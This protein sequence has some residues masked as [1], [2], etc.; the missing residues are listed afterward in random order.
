MNAVSIALWGDDPMYVRGAERAARMWREALGAGWEVHLVTNKPNFNP[1]YAA[2]TWYIKFTDW[3][4]A[5]ARYA[6]GTLKKQGVSGN[7]ENYFDRV[8]F[9]DA[10]S[11]PV[12]RDVWAVQDWCK[13]E[14]PFMVIRDHPGHAMVPGGLWGLRPNDDFT[15]A[16]HGW[17][18]E[19][20]HPK[21]WDDQRWLRAR[22]WPLMERKGV[23]IYDSARLDAA[24]PRLT[25]W[26]FCG[27][28]FD[29]Y[30]KAVYHD[31]R[32]PQSRAR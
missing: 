3:G 9:R 5:F 8:I 11:V 22:V 19:Y 25:D 16:Y 31:D 27:N 6:L 15:V 4:G 20:P 21:F 14:V 13:S 1:E 30:G 17:E 7:L 2:M 26:D 18:S 10:D 23:E 12:P 24:C 28:K 29:A 32:V